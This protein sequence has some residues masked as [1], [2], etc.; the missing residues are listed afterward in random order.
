MLLPDSQLKQL[1][2]QKGLVNEKV[3]EEVSELAKNS[4]ISFGEAL[5][6]KEIISDENLGKLT[7]EFL[8][9]PFVTLGKISIPDEIVH[10]IPE[11]FAKKQNV[12][13]FGRDK[14]GIKVAMSDPSNNHVLE[15][16][17]K[18]TNENITAYLATEKDI[19]N[20]LHIYRKNLQKTFDSLLKEEIGRTNTTDSDEAPIAKIVDLLIEYAYEDKASDIHIEPEEKNSVV[21]FRIDGILHNVLYVPKILNDRI[22]TRI[23]VLAKLRTDEHMGPQDGKIRIAVD[24]DNLD[25]RVS[26]LPVVDGEKAVLRLLTSSVEHLSLLDLG[27][28]EKDLKKVTEAYSKPYGMILSTGPTGA[29][30]TTAIYAIL[31]ILNTKEK[32]ITT[33]EDPVEYRIKGVNQIQVNTKANLTFANGLRSILRQDPNIIFVGEIRDTETAAIAVN[34]ALTGH[35]VLSTLHTNDAATA[36][37][38]LIDMRVEPF[39]VASTVNVIIAQRLLRRICEMCRTQT[40]I[41]SEELATHIPPEIITKNFGPESEIKTYIGKG[42]KL[43]HYTGYKGR[44]GIFEVLE[45][46]KDIKKLIIEK[47][48]SDVIA[49]T[50]INEG[51]T[52][53]LDD[54]LK[55]VSQGITTIE[56][57]LRVIKVEDQYEN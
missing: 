11:R 10:V 41:R 9:Y 37:P 21:R 56:E 13:P 28:N 18:K 5:V 38:R 25:L 39:L 47:Q 53:M 14:D 2:A 54:G 12:I 31:K 51:M 1:V 32:N 55:R 16:I 19:H 27:M 8:K 45:V 50:A 35:L 52:T 22:I 17:A 33:I 36:L 49:R 30:K 7:A 20:T 46:T 24:H 57:V 6:E 3:L 26:I 29:G 34:A 43:C 42:C 23:K 4:S 44:V 48:D 40:S 15:M